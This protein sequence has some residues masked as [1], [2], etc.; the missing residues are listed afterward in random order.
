MKTRILLL[1]TI[2]ATGLTASAQKTFKV[3]AAAN[4]RSVFMEIKEKYEKEYAG[5][6]IDVTFGSSGTFVQQIIN[7]APFDFFMAADKDFPIK[8]Q[9]QGMT[10]GKVSTYAYGK[11]AIWS[12]S[13][14]LNQGVS[15]LK[16]PNIKRIS[17][18]KPETAPYGDRA[19]EFLKKQNLFSDLQSKIVYGDNISAAAQYAFTGNAEVGFIALS[20][21]IAPEMKEKGTY[22]IVPQEMYTRIEQACVLIKKTMRN[23]EA[24]K[25]MIY[26]L[27]DS[28]NA[29]WEEYGYTK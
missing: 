7:G 14:P 12:N 1:T 6:K 29:L 10:Y 13:L 19:V 24:E 4:L 23:L 9:N 15:A 25:F 27:G 5:I 17:I 2:I 21:A 26:I 20:L 16:N 8:L 18:A 3:A 11:L 22:Y 28:C